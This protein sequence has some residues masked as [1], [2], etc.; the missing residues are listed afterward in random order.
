MCGIAGIISTNPYAHLEI[1]IHQMNEK[2]AHR[3]P[4]AD[5][6][7]IEPGVALGHSRLAII[8]LSPAGNQPFQD[9]SGRYFMLYNGE[10]YNYLELKAE[11]VGKY[12]FRTQSDTE[13][14]LAAYINWGPE[15]L[16]R[17]NGMFGLAIWDKEER[18]LFLARDRLGIKPIYY[19]QTE[20]GVLFASEIRAILSTGWTNKN[21]NQ[22][23]LVDYLRYQTVHAP[24]T[25][26]D[27]IY[28]LPAACFANY[29]EGQFS[30]KKYWDLTPRTNG[31][32]YTDRTQIQENVRELLQK[33]VS[34]RLMSDVPL[35]AFLS[36]G[37]DSSAIVA[38]MAQASTQPVNTFSVVFN[39]KK[40]DES[41]YANIIAE[42]YKT[43]HTPIL[44][45]P[46]DFLDALPTALNAMDCPSGDGINSYVVS[47]VTRE[48]GITVA[49]SGLGGDELFGGYPVFRQWTQLYKK[50]W[51]WNFPQLLRNGTGQ[52]AKAVLN[53]HKSDRLHELMTLP[54]LE[55]ADAYPVFRKLTSTKDIAQLSSRLPAHHNAV[56]L[57]LENERSNLRGMPL[58]S[59]VSLG[60][61]SSYT[62]NVLLRDTD[63]MSMAS[64]LEVRVPFFDHE[65]VEYVLGIPDDYKFPHTPKQLLVESLGDLLP[66]EVVHRPKMGFVFPWADWL[67]HEL[68]D[69]A[70]QRLSQLGARSLFNEEEIHSVWSRFL[71]KDKKISWVNIWTLVVLEEWL[72]KHA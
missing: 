20:K 1:L 52:L 41:P 62:Q 67:R 29:K 71:K 28:M 63:Q 56:A 45:K 19:C 27:G 13:V 35:G 58:L 31:R 36:G 49:L 64:S 9:N 26:I 60:E 34:R 3:G 66:Y 53:N 38:L 44:L 46:Q 10:L 68:R 54:K 51:L 11:L 30:I 33:A 7:F 42:K 8:D 37:I 21:I 47:K 24:N 16:K 6:F 69:F 57:L 4:D 65:L 22:K 14:I 39:E 50:R 72:N 32:L 12:E 18:N 23:A 70:S 15:C 5:G 48:A 61:I 55:F 2:I 43:N 59:Q 40:Y 17:F 25:L